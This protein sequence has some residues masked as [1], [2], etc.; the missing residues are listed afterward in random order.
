M[1]EAVLSHTNVLSPTLGKCLQYK[2]PKGLV[3]IFVRLGRK[4]GSHNFATWILFPYILHTGNL[5]LNELIL[6]FSQ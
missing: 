4:S 5:N 1:D 6:K 3:A 2:L